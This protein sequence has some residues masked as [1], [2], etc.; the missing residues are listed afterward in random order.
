MPHQNNYSW[1]FNIRSLKGGDPNYYQVI[2]DGDIESF[3][4]IQTENGTLNQLWVLNNQPR[5]WKRLFSAIQS[6]SKQVRI[7][8]VDERLKD[9]LLAIKKSGLQNTV[10]QYE[11]ELS[12]LIEPVEVK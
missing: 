10:N 9:K 3:F 8:N 11:M 6:I 2:N 7:I 4:S 5:N 1:D 12:L